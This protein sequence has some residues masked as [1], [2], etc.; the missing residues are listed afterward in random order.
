MERVAAAAGLAQFQVYLPIPVLLLRQAFPHTVGRPPL[1]RPEAG[2]P[3]H[4]SV[5]VDV[6]R[7]RLVRGGR[8]RNAGRVGPVVAGRM[9]AQVRF[10]ERLREPCLF[11]IAWNR[12]K[13]NGFF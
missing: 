11:Q 10:W 9:T 1:V 2:V 5:G 8:V 3:R 13:S 12:S 7:A 4:L 6:A